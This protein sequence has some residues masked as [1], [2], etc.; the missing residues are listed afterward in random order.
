ML[1][2]A[3]AAVTLSPHKKTFKPNLGL[4]LKTLV[5]C[6]CLATPLSGLAQDLRLINEFNAERFADL[7]SEDFRRLATSSYAQ[8]GQNIFVF[9]TLYEEDLNPNLGVR[10]TRSKKVRHIMR[11]ENKIFFDATYSFD[12]YGRRVTPIASLA[13]RKKFI[14]LTG[15]SFT[16]GH[17]LN[18]NQTIN[19]F[20]A[21]ELPE[22]FPYNYAI[23]ASGP[24]VSMALAEES[25]FADEIPQAEGMM[26]YVSLGTEHIA[27][28]T[29]RL[30][31][32]SWLEDAPYYEKLGDELVRKGTFATGRFFTT[33]FYFFLGRIL[34]FFGLGNRIFPPL[35]SADSDFMCAL[36]M[37]LKHS[38]LQHHPSSRFIYYLHP[39]SA[40]P[41]ELGECLTH[42]KVEWLEGKLPA[43]P[44]L[45]IPL[46]GHP[47]AQANKFIAADIAAYL[48]RTK[49]NLSH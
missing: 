11:S 27:R 2:K 20:L 39:F 38:F 42:G 13:S 44:N 45:N 19:Y 36:V 49:S 47:N 23:S 3:A 22:Y 15:C 40:Q 16:F 7:S 25:N 43:L 14:L 46:D 33:K 5:I 48:K 37:K 8:D 21:K 41:K 29:G 34:T 10:R 30:P 28:A 18:D 4:A 9:Q 26:I 35:D 6:F 1:R 12:Q 32:V 31:S 24:H 17:G